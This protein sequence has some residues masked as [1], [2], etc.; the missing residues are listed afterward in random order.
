M[1]VADRIRLTQKILFT[2]GRKFFSDNG[3]FLATGLAFNLLLYSIPF[4]LLLISFFGYTILESDRALKEV[5]SIL[6]ALLPRSQQ[7]FADNVAAIVASRGL[8][9]FVGFVSFFVFSSFLFGSVRIVLN[10]V[11]EVRRP[12]TYFR[13]LASDFLMM[14]I[15]AAL[16]MLAIGTTWVAAGVGTAAV[17]FPELAF[18]IEPLATLFTKIV[19]LIVTGTVFYVAYRFSPAATLTRPALWVAALT[20][21]ILLELAKQAFAWYVA[22]AETSLVLYG[23]LSGVVLFFVWLYYA[24]VVFVL[25]AEVGWAYDHVSVE[26]LEG[27]MRGNQNNGDPARDLR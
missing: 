18:F 27:S 24:S 7:T 1:T 21:T 20:G 3:L 5:E 4:S 23:I 11:F 22:F 13:G 9:G 10:Q 16:A 15:T 8:L 19:S 2:A 26:S 12:R 17:R 25:G 6:R 14:L